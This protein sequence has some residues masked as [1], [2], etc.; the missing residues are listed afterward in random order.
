MA[1]RIEE[2]DGSSG[3][4]RTEHLLRSV[5]DGEIQDVRWRLSRALE[6]LGYHVITEEPLHARRRA[7]GWAVYQASA[8]ILDYP[9]RLTITL[10]P[11]N[12]IAT[13]A[14]FDY[15]VKHLA[16]STKGDQQTLRREAEA[17]IALA[18]AGPTATTCAACGTKQPY[19]SRFCRLCGAPNVAV[20]PAELE[21]MRLTAGARAGQHL[22]VIGILLS[23][24]PLLLI[25]LILLLQIIWKVDHPELIWGLTGGVIG[26]LIACLG[27]VLWGVTSLRHTLNPKPGQQQV[28]PL[29]VPQAS[30]VTHPKSFLPEGG[31]ESV[32][33]VTTKKLNLN[34]KEPMSVPINSKSDDIDT[35]S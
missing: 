6:A 13:L 14:N 25:L 22:I 28:L 29:T 34:P 19:D 3:I 9:V 30:L 15:S 31:Q 23:L 11:L 7:R 8:N 12:P 2:I 18:T 16:L 1:E 27:I 4:T 33:Q 35:M 10:K 26:G 21:V 32:T 17:I 5:L 24:A 20:A